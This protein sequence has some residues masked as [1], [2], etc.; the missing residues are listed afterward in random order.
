MGKNTIEVIINKKVYRLASNDSEEK[1]QKLAR[2]VDLKIAEFET[3]IGYSKL[4]P[5]YQNLMLSLNLAQ[6][7][8][9]VKEELEKMDQEA[10]KRERELYEIKHE[11][12][13]SK[14]Q[15]ESLQKMLEEYKKQVAKLQK[16]IIQLEQ[17]NK[18][19]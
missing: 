6:D 10:S 7:Y 1:L 18:D 3:S 12:L 14:I 4:N 8:F 5:E 11:M 13:D 19:E 15:C 2:Y 9:T 17:R 16:E